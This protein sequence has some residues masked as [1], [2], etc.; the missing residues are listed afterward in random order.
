MNPACE[1]CGG[2]CCKGL[3]LDMTKGMSGD[4][5]RWMELH[6]YKRGTFVRF[7]AQCSKLV[8]GKCSIYDIRPGICRYSKVGGPECLNALKQL[9]PE[10]Y[11]KILALIQY[12]QSGADAL[13]VVKP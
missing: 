12:P 9:A 4:E 6:G 7:D 10:K 11:E 5:K 13:K 3:F 2:T 1:A 8:D